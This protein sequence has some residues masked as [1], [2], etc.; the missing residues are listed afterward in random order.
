MFERSSSC[1]ELGLTSD[2]LRWSL[3][4]RDSAALLFGLGLFCHDLGPISVSNSE[5]DQVAGTTSS[6]LQPCSCFD[7]VEDISSIG[8]RSTLPGRPSCLDVR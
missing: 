4:A 1:V 3:Q 6:F 2:L 5:Y 8:D 7:G